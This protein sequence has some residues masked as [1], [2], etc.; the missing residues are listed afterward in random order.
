MAG[1]RSSTDMAKPAE[2]R[3]SNFSEATLPIGQSMMKTPPRPKP[4]IA[5]LTIR[6]A[7]LFHKIT[8]KILESVN[9]RSSVA[10]E[11]MKIPG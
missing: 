2:T 5:L 10:A 7:R 1:M 11:I 8:S 6:Y 3:V 9:S 4:K